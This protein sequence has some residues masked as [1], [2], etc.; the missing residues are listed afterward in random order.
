MKEM[1]IQT[2][3]PYPNVPEAKEMKAMSTQ[4]NA[5]EEKIEVRAVNT[6]TPM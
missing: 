6:Q 5:K 1:T 2:K 4:H 3:E